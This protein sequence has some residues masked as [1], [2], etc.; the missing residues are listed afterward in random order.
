MN[1][2]ELVKAL[3]EKSG[4]DKKTVDS[5]ISALDEIVKSKVASGESVALAGL[6]IFKVVDRPAR[7]A[8]NPMTGEKVQ[9]PA[10]RVT[11]FSLS[12]S[13][14]DIASGNSK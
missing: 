11:K 10:K 13:L 7:E 9:V 8:R 12:K 14:K 6:G 5:I 3:I 1:K 2:T 4:S